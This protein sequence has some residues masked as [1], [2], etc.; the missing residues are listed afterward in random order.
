[1]PR[2]ETARITHSASLRYDITRRTRCVAGQKEVKVG[3]C[4][5]DVKP[6]NLENCPYDMTPIAVHSVADSF[7][8]SCD[9]C[10]AAWEMHGS[11]IRRLRAPDAETVRAVRNG[12]FPPELLGG[13]QAAATGSAEDA[14]V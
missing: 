8:I 12:L 9:T 13:E 6:V 2:A 11:L 3:C 14:A 10:G 4:S 1:M 7:L 5:V